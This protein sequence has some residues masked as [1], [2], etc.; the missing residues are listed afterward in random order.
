MISCNIAK[1]CYRLAAAMTGM[2]LQATAMAA[3]LPEKIP[4]KQ[5]TPDDDNLVYRAI[6]A[7]LFACAVAYGIAWLIKRYLPSAGVRKGAGQQLQ[8]LEAIRLTQRSVLLRV[9]WGGEELLLGENEHGVALLGKRPFLEAG[10]A[11]A[12]Q[13]CPA[14]ELAALQTGEASHD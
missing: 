3:A 11:D 5:T 14:P 8:R 13:N 7:F 4:F 10:T 9:R 2:L 6:A 1:P 12:A